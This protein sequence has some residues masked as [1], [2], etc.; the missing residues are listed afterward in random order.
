MPDPQSDAALLDAIKAGDIERVKV[1]VSAAPALIDAR[2]TAGDSAVL[3]AV[4]HR[5]PDIANL[6]TISC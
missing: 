2:S 3:T 1:L 4:Y 6:P 5:H